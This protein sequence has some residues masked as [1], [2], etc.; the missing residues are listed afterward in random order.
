MNTWQF[1]AAVEEELILRLAQEV[2][3]E[4]PSAYLDFL[5]RGNGGEGEIS[6]DPGYLILWKAS[7]VN[8]FNDEYEV[9][10]YAPGFWAFGSNGGGELFAFDFRGGAPSVCLLPM[11]GLEPNAAM[12]LAPSFEA[13]VSQSFSSVR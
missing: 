10:K 7:E 1:E 5:R 4:L 12:P 6:S 2:A 13:F 9:P 8:Q 3:F 11:I